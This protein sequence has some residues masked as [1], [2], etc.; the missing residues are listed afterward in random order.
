MCF[1]V[2]ACVPGLALNKSHPVLSKEEQQPAERVFGKFAFWACWSQF[3]HSY[4]EPVTVRLYCHPHWCPEQLPLALTPPQHTYNTQCLSS[5]LR[6]SSTPPLASSARCHVELRNPIK[7]SLPLG[8]DEVRVGRVKVRVPQQPLFYS[9]PSSRE[10]RR[11]ARKHVCNKIHCHGGAVVARSWDEGATNPRQKKGRGRARS[12]WAAVASTGTD[13]PR[14]RSR[15]RSP[16]RRCNASP[17][18]GTSHIPRHTVAPPPPSPSSSS[19]FLVRVFSPLHTK[20]T[21]R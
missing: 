11:G 6:C 5:S 1:F 8:G 17:L 16:C 18:G 15:R 13:G 4:F 20:T 10:R 12:T 14:G 9:N 3:F 19:F 2:H 21:A 7:G